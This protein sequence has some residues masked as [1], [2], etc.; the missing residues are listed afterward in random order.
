MTEIKLYQD[1]RPH[2]SGRKHLWN[3]DKLLL[4][5]KIL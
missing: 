2:D 5:Y 4:Y 1:D 3:V